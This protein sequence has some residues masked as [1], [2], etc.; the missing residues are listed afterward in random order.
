VAFLLRIS[1]AIDAF[2][3]RLGRW[4]AWLILV[5][6]LI[7]TGNAVV[8][9]VYSMSSN[10]W[11]DLQWI[12][13]SAVFLLCAPWTL[14]SNAHVRIDVLN[15]LLSRQAR[16][17]IDII[18]HTLFLLPLTIVMILTGVPFFRASYRIGEQSF[19]PEGLPQWP[20]KSL[21]VIGFAVLFAQGISELIKRVAILRGLIPDPHA[22]DESGSTTGAA[23]ML[24]GANADPARPRP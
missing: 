22:D 19:N 10:A 18:G 5:A 4:V 3:T 14:L 1:G 24:E 23:V 9:K 17:W 20:A 7:S 12:F 6:V 13:F 15:S 2:N 21:V 8:R 11:L 16:L